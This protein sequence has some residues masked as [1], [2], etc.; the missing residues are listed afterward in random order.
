MRDAQ[1]TFQ[2]YTPSQGTPGLFDLDVHQGQIHAHTALL[3]RASKQTERKERE[4][5]QEDPES[6]REDKTKTQTRKKERKK[7][8]SSAS[9]GE[10]HPKSA[11]KPDGRSTDV[12]G[13]ALPFLP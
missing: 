12:H 8:N 2:C 10:N 13:V 4:Q 1:R 6:E 5:K 11:P 3:R 9:R 7:K